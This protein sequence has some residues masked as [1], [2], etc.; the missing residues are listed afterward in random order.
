MAYWVVPLV[1]GV[2]YRGAVPLLWILAPGAVFLAC[3]EVT[4]DLLRGR[5]SRFVAWAE[6]LAAVF[7]IVLLFALLS[8][9]GVAG[10][11]IASTFAYR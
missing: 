10:A 11:A 1:Y 5:T 8:V 9:V 3:G 4:G 7:T 6:G 2:S